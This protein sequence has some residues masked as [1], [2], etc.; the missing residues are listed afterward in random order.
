MSFKDKL[1]TH[2]N[3]YNFYKKEYK[4]LTEKTKQQKQN[5][6]QLKQENKQQ[7]QN[8]N[9]LKQDL[10]YLNKNK[11]CK[12]IRNNNFSEL[13]IAIKSP[14]TNKRWGDY[15]F[16]LSLQKSLKK[17]GFNV[18]IQGHENWYSTEDKEDIVIVLRGLEEYNPSYKH[19][20]LM[21]N[22]S[23]PNL[24]SKEENEKYDIVFIASEKY[25]NKVSKD[26]NTLVKPLIQCTDLEVFYPK[27]DNELKN[28]LLFVG[29]TRGVYREI[30]KD[31]MNTKHEVSIYGLGWKEFIDEKY[32]KGEFIE[33]NQLNKYYSSCKI[34]L[35]DHWKDMV[36]KEFTSNRL[37]DALACGTFI[38]SD[39]MSTTEH[40]LKGSVVTYENSE[41][42]D[43]KINYYLNHPEE[44]QK[45]AKK[46]QEEVLKNH[47]FDNRVNTIIETLKELDYK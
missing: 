10:H 30:I 26:V 35:N 6:N 46:G 34:L 24:I 3:S 11:I 33:N 2:S 28:D 19:L 31:V 39:K 32:I 13:T 44:R 42:L 4:K 15:F 38:I 40:L 16:A 23:H 17:K 45:L 12:K 27:I 47:T 5:I 20:N 18:I 8:I 29:N 1:L 43:E 36:E 9:Q 25:A 22:I 41:D 21:W 7:K 37:F 14:H